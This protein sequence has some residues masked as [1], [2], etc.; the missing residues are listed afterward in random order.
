MLALAE[1]EPKDV[2]RSYFT[3]SLVALPSAGRVHCVP[4]DSCR[5]TSNYCATLAATRTVHIFHYFL[6]FTTDPSCLN[7]VTLT[8]SLRACVNKSH[9]VQQST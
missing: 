4:T 5:V 1:I 9:R 2:P 8:R 6:P 7:S 3:A